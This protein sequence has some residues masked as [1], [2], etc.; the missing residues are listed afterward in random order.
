MQKKSGKLVYFEMD[1]FF[2][3]KKYIHINIYVSTYIIVFWLFSLEIL[4]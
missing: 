4:Q 3:N 1:S 2:K